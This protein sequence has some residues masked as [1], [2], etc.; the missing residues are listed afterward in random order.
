MF[1]TNNSSDYQARRVAIQKRLASAVTHVNETSDAMHSE[2][3]CVETTAATLTR[4]QRDMEDEALQADR[5]CVDFV[6]TRLQTSAHDMCLN[7]ISLLHGRLAAFR[8]YLN[9]MSEL[10]EQADTVLC[11]AHFDWTHFEH[12]TRANQNARD[13]AAVLHTQKQVIDDE[14]GEA[15]VADD[16]GDRS[17]HLEDTNEFEWTNGCTP[18]NEHERQ[19]LERLWHRPVLIPR[20][21]VWRRKTKHGKDSD[22]DD[23]DN[24][25]YAS[26]DLEECRETAR[27]RPST[28]HTPCPPDYESQDA[29]F[30]LE[31]KDCNSEKDDKEY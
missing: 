25:S 21:A 30:H 6:Q 11:K 5:A 28:P 1:S 3:L 18:K 23:N 31:G 13:C 7:D 16:G 15:K 26:T 10:T 20:Y 8:A 14:E 2:A 12:A 29:I 4:I 24:D 9:R 17:A 27:T 22:D 19:Q